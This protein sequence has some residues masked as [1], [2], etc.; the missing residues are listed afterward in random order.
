MFSSLPGRFWILLLVALAW[1]RPAAA[2][3]A[4]VETPDIRV[5]YVDATESFLA[6]FAAR[7]FLN[8]FAFHRKLFDFKPTERPTVLL[9]D[10]MDYGNAAAGSVPRNTVQVQIAP[11]SYLFETLSANER[12]TMLAN[13]AMPLTVIALVPL[14]VV[15]VYWNFALDEGAVE[16]TFGA[17]SI[18][19]NAVLAWPWRHYFWPLLVWRGR[20]DYG[21]ATGWPPARVP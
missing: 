6:P 21:L 12:L 1:P 20:P 2:Q 18:A 11:L 4:K 3:L 13:R 8:S 16:W 15:I 14:N 7:T 9:V 5:V 10:F 19:L 17:L